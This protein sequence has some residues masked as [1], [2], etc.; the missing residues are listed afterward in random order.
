MLILKGVKVPTHHCIQGKAFLHRKED[1]QSARGQFIYLLDHRR[2]DRQ[3]ESAVG[4]GSFLLAISSRGGDRG[5][6]SGKTHVL[7]NMI[8]FTE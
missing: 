3:T 5:V 4:R 8:L 1:T 7:S 2:T 6:M